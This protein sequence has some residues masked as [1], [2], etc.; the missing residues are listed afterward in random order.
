MEQQWDVEEERKGPAPWM[1]IVGGL[2]FIA[3]MGGVGAMVM[4]PPAPVPAPTAFAPYTATDKAF[5]CQAPQGWETSG[6]GSGG[7]NSGVLFKKGD[8]KIDV[9]ADLAGSLMGDIAAATDRMAGGTETAG[10]GISMPGLPGVDLGAK[11]KPPV[12]KLHE[13]GKG[14]VAKKFGNYEE[15]PMQTLQ[16]RLGDARF[17]EFTGGGGSPFSPNVHGYRVTILGGERRVTVVAVCRET[18]WK[19]LKPAFET[20]ITS[21]APGGG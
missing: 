6:F 17:N 12:E 1:I 19:A 14:S 15:K 4:R 7:M 10:G 13:K 3:A 8:A 2:V 18:D 16:S 11:R 20:T 5:V 9:T 21:L